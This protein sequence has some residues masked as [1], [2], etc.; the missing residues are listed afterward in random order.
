MEGEELLKFIEPDYMIP[1]ATISE[2]I[3]QRSVS[4]EGV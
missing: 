4:E 2:Q 1:L 3:R